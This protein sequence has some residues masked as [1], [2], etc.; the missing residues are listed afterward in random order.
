MTAEPPT[1]E[2]YV[3]M[4]PVQGQVL[5]R[6]REYV[7]G[8]LEA[9]I[10]PRSPLGPHAVRVSAS[11]DACDALARVLASRSWVDAVAV[12]PPAVYVRVT[13]AAL[14]SWV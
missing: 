12:R 13:T 6:L 9:S 10:A 14:R 2:E 4:G 5:A 1:A 3:G 11:P 7:A 8:E